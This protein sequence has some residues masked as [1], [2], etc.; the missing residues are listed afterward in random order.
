[1]MLYSEPVGDLRSLMVD[2]ICSLSIGSEMG[3][4]LKEMDVTTS[5]GTLA[6]RKKGTRLE[7]P[8]SQ[9]RPVKAFVAVC[10]IC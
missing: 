7:P 5:S 10:D 3:S 2:V 9:R 8:Y 4:L 6:G 1:M